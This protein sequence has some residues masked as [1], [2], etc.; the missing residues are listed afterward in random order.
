M[1]RRL[2]T[3]ALAALCPALA[4]AGERWRIEYFYDPAEDS[5]FAIADLA[6]PSARVGMAA[7]QIVGR[8]KPKPYAVATADGGRTWTPVAVPEVAISLFF[9]DERT[10]W[11]V[12]PNGI[13]KAG[14]PKK[15]QLDPGQL[16][17]SSGMV[18]AQLEGQLKANQAEQANREHGIED[19]QIRI[20]EYQG[21]LNAE[22]ASEQ[23]LADLTRGYEQ[24]KANYDDLL[25]KKN[26]SEMATSMEQMQQG[27]RFKVLDPPSLPLKPDFPNRL[28]LCGV[29]L[30][31]GL[32]LGLVVVGSFEVMD[33]RLYSDNGIKELLP[34]SIISE[35]PVVLIP[36]EEQGYKEK[37]M[38]GWA[39]AALVT[40]TIL[41]GSAFSYLHD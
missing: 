26:A 4:A 27:E 10:G 6:F 21:R 28:K 32:M 16:D 30:G 1:T 36:S 39:M 7:G 20:R 17:R 35:I 18:I 23:E 19:L 12:A 37:R 29:G 25:K 33:D 31:V 24:S 41:A 38:L 9:L 34:V 11:L 3:L 5:E 40:A 2:M 15:N 8:G 14:T 22:P 13:W